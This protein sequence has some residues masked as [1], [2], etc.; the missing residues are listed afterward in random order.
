MDPEWGITPGT[1]H[2]PEGKN[3]N[4]KLQNSGKIQPS[5]IKLAVARWLA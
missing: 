4:F 1:V 5:S 2:E 3:P